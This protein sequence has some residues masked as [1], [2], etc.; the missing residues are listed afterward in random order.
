M[1]ARIKHE[2]VKEWSGCFHQ[3]ENT[4]THKHNLHRVFGTSESKTK[5]SLARGAG[6]LDTIC[7]RVLAAPETKTKTSA[8]TFGRDVWV[9]Y[10]FRG[11][12]DSANVL[13]FQ[14]FA[15]EAQKG[16]IQTDVNIGAELVTDWSLELLSSDP[17][18]PRLQQIS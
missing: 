8:P 6:G 2:D 18:P 15:E 11:F 7:H 1:S 14:V 13:V 3:S 4:R 16:G 10:N 5:N 9:F 17:F 12:H